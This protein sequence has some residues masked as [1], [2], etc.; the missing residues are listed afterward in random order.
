MKYFLALVLAIGMAFAAPQHPSGGV[1]GHAAGG[2][3]IA[4]DGILSANGNSGTFTA[5][6]TNDLK[7]VFASTGATTGTVA[8]PGTFTQIASGTSG[9]GMAWVIGCNRSSSS[10]DTASGTWTGGTVVGMSY[11]GVATGTTGNCNT[12]AVGGV[13]PLNNTNG[14]LSVGPVTLQ[15]GTGSWVNAFYST[16]SSGQCVPAGLT[17]QAGGSF[18]VTTGLDTN[19]VVTTF[20][21]QTCSFAGGG[22]WVSYSAE[23]KNH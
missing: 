17:Q 4:L 8:I 19:G 3:T 14:I 15:N 21:N 2:T 7:I 22:D 20:A 11:S 18:H 12:T 13:A 5:T 1:T 6:A 10:A 16:V 23:I 9:A